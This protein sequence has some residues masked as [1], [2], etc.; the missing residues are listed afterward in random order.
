MKPASIL[1]RKKGT[2]PCVYTGRQHQKRLNL[3]RGAD[4]LNGFDGVIKWMRGN[5]EGFLKMLTRI[6]S[7]F[8]GL[9]IDLRADNSPCRRA[10]RVKQ[11]LSDH[12]NSSIHYLPPYLPKLNYKERLWRMLLCEETIS[13]YHE[14]VM[15]LEVAVFSRSQRRKRLKIRKLCQL[16]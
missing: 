13:E 3:F 2:K 8:K 5:T 14:T 4:P 12:P 15:H 7:R 1:I 16:S 11:S 6:V 10:S 9:T